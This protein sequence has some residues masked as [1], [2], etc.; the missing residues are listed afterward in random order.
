MTSHVKRRDHATCVREVWQPA[1]KK[2]QMIDCIE[3]QA[4]LADAMS[5]ATRRDP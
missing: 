2:L 3:S 5:A 4:P 1:V